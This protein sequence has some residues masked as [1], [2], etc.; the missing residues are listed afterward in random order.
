MYFHNPGISFS[1]QIIQLI[2]KFLNSRRSYS[3][4]LVGDLPK[5]FLKTVLK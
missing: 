2:P 1:R 5:K 3:S 4:K